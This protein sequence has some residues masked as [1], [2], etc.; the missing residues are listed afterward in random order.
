LDANEPTT[1]YVTTN[2]A[3]AEVVRAALDAEGITARTTGTNQAGLVGALDEV[4]VVVRASDAERARALIQ[5]IHHT[6]SI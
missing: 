6:E 2:P 1:V 3:E 5:S 4:T